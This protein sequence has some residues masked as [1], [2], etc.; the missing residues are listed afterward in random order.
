[1][2]LSSTSVPPPVTEEQFFAERQSIWSS[3]CNGSTAAAVV[4]G[5]IVVGMAIFLV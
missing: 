3:F 1:M 5:L 2:A 4:V